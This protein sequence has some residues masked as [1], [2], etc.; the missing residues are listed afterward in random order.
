MKKLVLA[1]VVTYIV[2]MASN[3]LINSVWLMP[4]Y[5]AISASHRSIE[6]IMHRFWALALGQLFYAIFFVYI[7]ARGAEHKSWLAQGVRYGIVMTLFTV[8]P[9]SLTQYDVYIVP[10]MLVIKW[11]AA[12]AVQML[13]LGIIVAAIYK[14]PESA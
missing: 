6:G 11:M 9:V 12:G 2:L 5:N 8:I 7:Y 14:Q 4:D 13:L 1:A 10:Y 3:Y